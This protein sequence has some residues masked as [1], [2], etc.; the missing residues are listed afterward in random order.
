V[1]GN[2]TVSLNQNAQTLITVS[3]TTSGTNS[4]A[5]FTA[6][7]S[8][9]SASFGKNSLAYTSY[10][11]ILANDCVFYNAVSGDISILNDFST[12]KIK[13]ATGGVSTAQATL[14][15]TGNF[16]IGTTTDVASSILTV[17]S[18]TR[19]FLPPRMTTTQKNAIASPATGLVV[20]DTTLN[21]LS[22]FTGL[23]WE[24]VTSL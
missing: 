9:G 17:E 3:N 2:T 11:T 4:S 21:K 7:S 19:G 5:F 14:F 15:T 8:N 13:L 23:V 10:K 1:Q 6:I 20:Y 16:A 22:V 18:T 24:T 12:G